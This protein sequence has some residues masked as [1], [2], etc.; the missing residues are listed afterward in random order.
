[1]ST[2]RNQSTRTHATGS[3]KPTH[4]A[5][6]VQDRDGQ[7]AYWQKIGGAWRHADG[8]GLTLQLSAVPLDGRIT[9]RVATEKTKK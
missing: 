3:N 5:Y 2:A 4:H 9:L 1:M 8:N 7:K 6:S